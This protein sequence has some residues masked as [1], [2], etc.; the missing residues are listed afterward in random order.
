MKQG[1]GQSPIKE[2]FMKTFLAAG[3]CAL[4]V[5]VPVHTTAGPVPGDRETHRG[6]P[7]PRTGRPASLI[8]A[9]LA[10]AL[11]GAPDYVTSYEAGRGAE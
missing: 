5:S 8:T 7:V 4:E 1:L 9:L 11:R 10:D 3:S 2:V 6:G